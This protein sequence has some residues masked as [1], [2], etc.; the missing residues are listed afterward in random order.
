MKTS[1]EPVLLFY[2]PG[3]GSAD[4]EGV[5]GWVVYRLGLH[6]AGIAA[7]VRLCQAEAAQDFSSS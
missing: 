7:M 3:L 4:R 1:G 2:L 6:T 5:T